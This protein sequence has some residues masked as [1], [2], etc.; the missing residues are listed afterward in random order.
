MHNERIGLAKSGWIRWR[1]LESLSSV[2]L[3][4]SVVFIQ[5]SDFVGNNHNNHNNHNMVHMI[6]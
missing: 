4:S 1:A 6:T 3:A 2:Q 5:T